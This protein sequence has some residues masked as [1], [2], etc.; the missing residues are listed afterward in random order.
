MVTGVDVDEVVAEFG[1]KTMNDAILAVAC[2]RYGVAIVKDAAFSKLFIMVVPSIGKCGAMH[3]IVADCRDESEGNEA[4][5]L[6]PA[7][8]G[9]V[10]TLSRLNQFGWA[11]QFCCLDVRDAERLEHR[12][13]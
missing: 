12:P 6:D 9:S 2:A 4:T 7:F 5:I 11:Y 3:Y 8:S 1:Q 10:W 13:L